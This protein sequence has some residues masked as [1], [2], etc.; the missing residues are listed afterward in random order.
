MPSTKQKIAEFIASEHVAAQ[1]EP[2]KPIERQ[3]SA[4]SVEI[5]PMKHFMIDDKPSNTPSR[6]FN[7]V[8]VPA[9]ADSFEKSPVLTRL[10]SS[11]RRQQQQAVSEQMPG[12]EQQSPANPVANTEGQKQRTIKVTDIVILDRDWQGIFQ[13]HP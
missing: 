7:S 9:P 6:S 12:G 3:S 13:D 2:R 8:E 10:R 11:R 4:V 1:E 5:L